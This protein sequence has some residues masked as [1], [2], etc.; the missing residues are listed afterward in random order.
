M[1]TYDALVVGAGHNGLAAAIHLASRGWS[2]AVVE[3][4]S[5]PGG[6]VKTAEL[7]EPGFRHD[8]GAMNLSMF[9]GSAFHK[10]YGAELAA[11]GL[12]F[13]PATDSFASLFRDGSHLGV[14]TDRAKTRAAIAALSAADAEAWDR[15][16]GGF[17]AL[18]TP[19]FGLLGAPMPSLAGAKALWQAFRQGGFARLYDLGQLLLSSP[20]AFLDR[21]FE[22]DRLKAMMAAWGLHLDFAPDT[23]GGAL[24]PYLE[25]MA[26]QAFGMVIGAGGADSMIKAMVGLLQA[27]GGTLLLDSPVREIVAE[28]GRASGLVLADGRRLTARRAVIANLH[29]K[30]VFGGL[31]PDTA[32]LPERFRQGVKRF[33]SGPGAM[34]I[35]LTLDALPNWRG[36]PEL[37]SFAYVHL[38]PDL[39][40]M[41]R[42]AAEAMAGLL[43]AEPVLVVGQPTALD[44]TRAPAGKHVLWVQVRV[45]PA[46]IKGD[47]AGVIAARAWDEVKEDYADRVMALIERSAPGLSASV[48]GRHVVSPLDLERDNPCLIGGDSLGGSHQLDQNFLFRPVAGWSRYKTPVECLYLCGAATWPG[49]GT[50]AG[51][52][53]LLAKALAR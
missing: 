42:V 52:G 39:A 17:G 47:A 13:V 46:E 33:R 6:A 7:I 21:H 28:G 26:T 53:F 19:L 29:P 41:N 43:P 40:M 20:R 36:A 5:A 8:L 25:T 37:A 4:A 38:A 11:H 22:N 49:A 35:H 34:M 16:N 1:S 15:M 10:T 30:L 50:G 51:S 2:V 48:R 14:S 3:A 44:P 31:L 18:A 9:A 23:A 27:K 32:P 12:Q 24:F 45:L